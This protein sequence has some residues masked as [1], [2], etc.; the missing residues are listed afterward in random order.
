VRCIK[1]EE[2]RR[3]PVDR[4]TIKDRWQQYLVRYLIQREMV[5]SNQ[6]T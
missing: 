2:E 3:V 1:D 6:V 5:T 4:H